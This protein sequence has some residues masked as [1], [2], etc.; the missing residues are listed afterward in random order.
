MMHIKMTGTLN[1]FDL[2][3]LTEYK[4]GMGPFLFIDIYMIW[5]LKQ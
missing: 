2:N 5:Y 3:E 1:V 4:S